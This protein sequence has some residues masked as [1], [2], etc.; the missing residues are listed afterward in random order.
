MLTDNLE[1]TKC[2]HLFCL[3]WKST[4][5]KCI[6]KRTAPRLNSQRETSSVSLDFSPLSISCV[7]THFICIWTSCL[8]HLISLISCLPTILC[9]CFG[10]G[11]LVGFVFLQLVLSRF[12]L[13]FEELRLRMK[14]KF[15]SSLLFSLHCEQNRTFSSLFFAFFSFRVNYLPLSCFKCTL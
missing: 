5:V 6:R 9:Q 4:L 14:G 13:K 7:N 12:N 1:N 15:F 8:G 3:Y 11:W 10:V 2:S